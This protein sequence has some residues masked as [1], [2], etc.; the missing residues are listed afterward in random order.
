MGCRQGTYLVALLAASGSVDELSVA[1]LHLQWDLALHPGT[2]ART[3]LILG[4]GEDQ[5]HAVRVEVEVPG[6]LPTARRATQT[7]LSTFH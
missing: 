2:V 4:G 7:P 1:S 6:C 5:V 3:V